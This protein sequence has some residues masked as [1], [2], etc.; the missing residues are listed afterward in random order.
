[1]NKYLFFNIALILLILIVGLTAASDSK[2]NKNNFLFK[3]ELNKENITRVILE[4]KDG[5]I[6]STDLNR[7]NTHDMESDDSIENIYIDYPIKADLYESSQLISAPDSWKMQINGYNLT[8]AGQTICIIDTGIDYTNSNLV[9]NYL[10]GY[11]FVNNDSDPLDDNG[12]GTH[13]AGII[14]SNGVLKGIAPNAKIVSIK[15]LDSD[16]KGYSSDVIKGIDWCTNNSENLNISSIVLSL[17]TDCS[18]NPSSCSFSF[19]GS[20]PFYNSIARATSKN[21][22]VLAATGNSGLSDTLP[23]PACVRNATPIAAS[24]KQDSLWLNSNRNSLVRILAPGKEIYSTYLNSY[25]TLSGTS[26]AVPHVAGAVAILKQFLVITNETRMPSQI[27][28]ILFNSG[29]SINN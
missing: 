20:S 13:I 28:E 7:K 10:T 19:C 4:M 15:V 22:I 17:S 2:A 5:T 3:T 18:L 26:M 9:Q 11:D 24:D 6:Q 21:I 29:K 27:D 23:S 14:A 12:H 16:G 8:G 25:K 1:M